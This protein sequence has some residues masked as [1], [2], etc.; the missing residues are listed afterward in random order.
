MQEKLVSI[1]ERVEEAVD[2]RRE[3]KVLEVNDANR[4]QN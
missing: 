1:E 4:V 2:F 3:L